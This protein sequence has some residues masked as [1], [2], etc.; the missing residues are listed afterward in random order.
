MDSWH[1]KRTNFPPSCIAFVN[2]ITLVP[3]LGNK[4]WAE[5]IDTAHMNL[6]GIQRTSKNTQR[7]RE[8]SFARQLALIST[9]QPKRGPPLKFR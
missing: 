6:S 7:N 3:R 5:K 8:M 4:R 9:N 2:N 1:A